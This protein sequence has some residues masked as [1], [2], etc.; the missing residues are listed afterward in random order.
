LDLFLPTYFPDLL[1][2]AALVR[3]KNVIF[4]VCDNY[5]KQTQR[6]RTYIAHAQG[7]L[8]LIVPIK[9]RTTGQRL[10]SYEVESESA[11]GWATNHWKSIQ[12]A[13]RTAPFFEFYEDDLADL[14]SSE[15]ITLQAHNLQ[16]IER[17]M[18]LIDWRYFG[19]KKHNIKV[20]FPH[21]IQVFESY[22][23]FIPNCSVLDALFNLGPQTLD[24]LQN[25]SLP[26]KDR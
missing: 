23:G 11:F 12:T 24:Y 26:S 16:I 15:S 17:L 5:Q 19:E 9:H 1:H 14:F 20:T 6:N 10:K 18:E 4:E 2:I 25:L 3:S 21:Y 22:N 13:Y 8:P 7:V